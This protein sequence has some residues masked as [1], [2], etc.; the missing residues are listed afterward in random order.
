MKYL[1]SFICIISPLMGCTTETNNQGIEI[2]HPKETAVE[3]V[4]TVKDDDATRT[5]ES[6]TKAEELLKKY[7][8]KFTTILEQTQENELI[9]SFQTKE[10]IQVYFQE[11][12]SKQLAHWLTETYFKERHDAVYIIPK[13]APLWFENNQ[14]YIFKQ[15][16]PTKYM[17]KQERKNELVGHVNFYAFF[18]QRENKW[19]IDAIEVVPYGSISRL[20]AEQLVR[21]ELH[22][23]S[24]EKVYIEFDHMSGKDYVIHVYDVVDNHTAT[25]G[26]YIVN[27]E[28]GMIQDMMSNHK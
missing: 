25:R 23:E 10:E 20:E 21:K 27:P 16:I 5:E 15:I 22:L 24:D 17:V 11:I 2:H 1:I 4:A 3:A 8:D 6:S 9:T 7:K 13:D 18:I 14:D 26:W 28:N 19:I 12:M